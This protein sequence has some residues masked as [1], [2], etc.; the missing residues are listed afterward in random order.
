MPFVQALEVIVGYLISPSVT[1]TGDLPGW[2]NWIFEWN[3]GFA[4]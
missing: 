1:W 4:N 3:R 2:Y